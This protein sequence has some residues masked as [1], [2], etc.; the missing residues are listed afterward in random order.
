M[1]SIEHKQPRPY[2]RH[3]HICNETAVSQ[4][5]EHRTVKAKYNDKQYVLEINKFPINRCGNCGASTTDL[6]AEAAIDLA[7]QK[8][9]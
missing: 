2:P 6:E 8:L 5:F 4:V 3:C 1:I 9:E 7:L